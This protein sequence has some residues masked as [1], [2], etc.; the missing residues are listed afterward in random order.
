MP[1][2]IDRKAK[3]E[4]LRLSRE[5][6]PKSS[7]SRLVGV[8]RPTVTAVIKENAT[9]NVEDK[10]A[11]QLLRRT[12]KA[13]EG[14]ESL[15]SNVQKTFEVLKT[16]AENPLY[17]H[18]VQSLA[19][20]SD[21]IFSRGRLGVEMALYEIVKDYS[22]EQIRYLFTLL[23]EV[24]NTLA[25][26][27]PA[28]GKTTVE[29]K[30]AFDQIDE[31]VQLANR[32]LKMGLS[33]VEIRKVATYGEGT[34]KATKDFQAFAKKIS[35]E[36]RLSVEDAMVLPIVVMNEFYRTKEALEVNEKVL[37][38]QSTQIERNRRVIEEQERKTERSW[39]VNKSTHVARG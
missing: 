13:K 4:I 12:I 28:F 8:S 38:Q 15:F 35:V 5:G 18:I 37:R 1:K 34:L 22:S 30:I 31:F 14:I 29:K 39:D 2:I 3:E 27:N 7:I 10:A 26:D 19:A 9:E 25:A 36:Y 32:I 20:E 33:E 16:A 6:V 11:H 24:F 17:G 23:N 21:F